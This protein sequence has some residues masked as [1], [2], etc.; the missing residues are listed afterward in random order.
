MSYDYN[1]LV[2]AFH[3]ARSAAANATAAAAAA[4]N[5]DAD[6]SARL[7]QLQK[8]VES[9]D[10]LSK[11]CPLTPLLWMQYAK[12]ISELAES[13]KQDGRLLELQ[14]L[15]LGIT[16]FSGSALLQ[17]RTAIVHVAIDN[18]ATDDDDDDDDD[19]DKTTA[20][21]TLQDAIENVGRGSHRNEDYIVAQLYDL[22]AQ[23]TGNVDILL[24]RSRVPMRQAN[25]TLSN[26]LHHF[27]KAHNIPMSHE[28]LQQI[29]EGRRWEARVLADFAKCEDAI[30]EVLHK[31]GL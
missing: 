5:D 24:Q 29:E 4:D 23:R 11:H 9:I 26:D 10:Q 18:D 21:S 13:L 2:E 7:L 17:L 28:I 14:T 30:D 8:A 3:S 1:A 12:T 19:N 27:C 31:H 22:L 6:H 20:N 25:S 16:E 15:Q